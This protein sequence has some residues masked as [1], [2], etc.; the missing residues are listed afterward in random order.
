MNKNIVKTYRILEN[1]VADNKRARL[2]DREV[3]SGIKS[4]KKKIWYDEKQNIHPSKK[5]C[6]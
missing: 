6:S 1:G 2:W 5:G 4:I 3:K